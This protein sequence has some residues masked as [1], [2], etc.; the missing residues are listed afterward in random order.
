MAGW[1]LVCFAT[2]YWFIDVKGYSRWAKPFIIFGMNAITVYVF[3]EGFG[4]L[5]D[6]VITL[7]QPDGSEISLQETIFK[8]FFLPLASPINASLIFA[9]CYLLFIFLI[10]W[11][12][13]KRKWFLRV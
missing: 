5:Y 7:R 8:T 4:K 6:S 3:S 11:I 2:F 9:L 1:A 10:V 13:W 12:R